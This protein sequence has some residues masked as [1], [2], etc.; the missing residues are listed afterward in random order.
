MKAPKFLY[1]ISVIFIIIITTPSHTSYKMSSCEFYSTTW[2]GRCRWPPR[3]S[4]KCKKEEN[5]QGGQCL[6][7]NAYAITVTTINFM[8]NDQ[9]LSE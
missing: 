4:D 7:G 8:Q 5:A 6:H 9:I 2:H 3:C 1:L